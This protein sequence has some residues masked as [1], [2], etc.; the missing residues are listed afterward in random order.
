[1]F[2]DAFDTKEKELYYAQLAYFEQYVQDRF[3]MGIDELYALPK[4]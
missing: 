2:N 1:M 3:S 4:Q